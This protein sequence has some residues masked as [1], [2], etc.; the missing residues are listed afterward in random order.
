M[1]EKSLII[2]EKPSVAADLVKVLPGKFTKTKTHYEGE[3]HVVSYAIGHLVSICYPEEID[4]RYKKWEL[5][6]LPI[7]PE[8]FPLKAINGTSSQLNAL[9]KLIRRKDI[10][11]IVNACDAGREG[12]LIFKYILQFT[13]TKSVEKKSIKR[14]WL[15]SMTTRAIREGF[16]NLRDNEAMQSLEETAKCRSES[17]WLIGIN[18]SRALTAYHSRNGGF[19]KTPCGRVQTPTLSLIVRREKERLAF[20]PQ[21]YY[22]LEA[23]FHFDLEGKKE[24]EKYCGMWIATDFKKEA[25]RPHDKASRLWDKE[26]AETIAAKCSGKPASISESS[27]LSKQS[28]SSLYD[29]TTLQREANSRFGFS[30]R[31]TL[32]IAQ[33]L[34]ERHKVLTYPRTDSKHLP[35]DYIPVVEK[36]L[37]IHQKGDLGRF[38]SEILQKKYLKKDKRI[39]DN[40]KISDHHA[41]I[42]TD[43]LPANLSEAEEKIFKMVSQRFMAVFFPPAEYL[44]TKRLS[45]VEA[46]TFLTEGKILKVPGWKA[47]YGAERSKEKD[48]MEPVPAGCEPLCHE[49][50]CLVADTK[51]PARYTEATLLS[52]MENCGKLVEDEEL[53]DAMKERG[54]GTPATRAST[55][56]GLIKEKYINRE[57]R[58]LVPSGKAFDLMNL[59]DGMKID[60]LRSP[61]LTGEW[62]YKM[63]LVLKGELTAEKFMEEIKK[64][65]EKIIERVKKF[66]TEGVGEEASFS[67]VGGRVFIENPTAFVSE[68]GKLSLRK[69]LGGKVMQESE[70]VA[71]INGETIG[72]FDDFRSKKGKPFSASLQVKESKINFLFQDNREDLDVEEILQQ[73]PLG[74]S[75]VNGENVYDTPVGYLSEAALK[76][77]EGG[78]RISKHILSK[79]IEAKHIGQ[80]LMEGKTELIEGFISK[81]RRPFDAFLLM[82]KKGKITFEF[83]PRK[84]KVKK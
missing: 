20:V 64:L 51:P 69:V 6:N 14:L 70:I 48:E 84:A 35:E 46:E 63:N 31:N 9:K 76:E 2:A 18:A 28:A 8:V 79:E 4:E 60:E 17:D 67:P 72:P 5:G 36:T 19:F 83:P 40:K 57:G 62:E 45:V 77:G 15:Q 74:V 56:E 37:D 42:P 52:A 22:Q 26:R 23:S 44:L 41:I 82:D 68:D 30:A 21:T 49:I 38:A 34:Y 71:L 11:E 24:P 66:A 58:E 50:E 81:K 65:T 73:E 54:L 43:I 12:E 78:L 32:S 25:D 16:E 47:V 7:I 53:R 13:K 1:N 39:F 3:H 10:V 55:I 29:L 27:K 61:E 59:I 33:A 80:L 75:P